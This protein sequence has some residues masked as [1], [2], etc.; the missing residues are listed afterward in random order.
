MS[1]RDWYL[2]L[3]KALE[4]KRLL[5]LDH[6]SIKL[7]VSANLVDINSVASFAMT[8]CVER[9][10]LVIRD[11][12]IIS[13]Q[14]CAGASENLLVTAMDYMVLRLTDPDLFLSNRRFSDD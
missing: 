4:R 8:A 11:S 3:V 7:S 13:L 12:H 10:G 14:A 2:M 1:N 5:E 9:G 6:R